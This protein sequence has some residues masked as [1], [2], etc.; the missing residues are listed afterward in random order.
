MGEISRKPVIAAIVCA[1]VALLVWGLG[2]GLG[3]GGNSPAGGWQEKLSAIQTSQTLTLEDLSL[4]EGSCSKSGSSLTVQ[5]ACTFAVA[6]FGGS[7]DL[8]PP[9]KEATLGVLGGAVEL[10]AQTEGVWAT[11]DLGA[12]DQTHLTFGTSGGLLT[13]LCAAISCT[14]VLAPGS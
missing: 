3:G 4:Q 7:F 11:Q 2:F 9:T 14:L 12:G 1:A 5:G 13:V 6:K 10:K 8:G